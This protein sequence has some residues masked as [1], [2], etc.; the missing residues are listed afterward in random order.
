[1]AAAKHKKSLFY[2]PRLKGHDTNGGVS[3]LEELKRVKSKKGWL[4]KVWGKWPGDES[5]E[6]LLTLLTK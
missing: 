4:K 2:Q 5:I 3:T 1:M 6:D